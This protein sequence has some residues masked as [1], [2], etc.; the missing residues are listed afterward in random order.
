MP[1]QTLLI[2]GPRGS[3]KS[4]AARLIKDQALD[5]PAHF[6]RLVP[7]QD[8]HTNAI[9]AYEPHDGDPLGSDWS[10]MHAVNYTMDRVF[11]TIPEGL[12]VVRRLDRRAFIVIE[13]DDDPTIR[14]A[15]PYDYRI[16]LMSPPSDLF[17]V[18]RTP[19]MAA[20]ALHQVMQDTAAFASEIFGLFDD[21]LLDDGEGVQHY[22]A[23]SLGPGGQRVEQLHVSESQIRHFLSSPLGAEIASRIQLQPGYHALVEADI[24]LINA[25]FVPRRQVLDECI[26]RLQKL[27]TR[28]RQ[29]ARRQSVLFWGNI[30]DEHNLARRKLLARLR[31]LLSNDV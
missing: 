2:S 24:V 5:S 13:A 12:R 25:A 19:D 30:L 29:D 31:T 15:Y 22:A 11:E 3:G 1:V 18:F 7:A 14:H 8:T 17:T 23:R 6:L 10:S 28:I 16:F 20:A 21:D 4:T 9:L 26:D 27:L